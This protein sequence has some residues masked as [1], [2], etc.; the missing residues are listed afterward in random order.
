M[1]R[2]LIGLG[3]AAGMVSSAMAAAAWSSPQNV[4]K[5]GQNPNAGSF[6]VGKK[7]GATQIIKCYVRGTDDEKKTINAIALTAKASGSPATFFLEF[8]SD[9][10]GKLSG[11]IC[12]LTG[13]QV[14]E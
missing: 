2:F 11:T 3:I 10:E 7:V 8:T 14:E 6:V 9:P 12:V 1:K 13:L 5:V 4:I